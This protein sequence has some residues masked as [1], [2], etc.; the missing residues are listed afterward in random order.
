MRVAIVE[1]CG[2]LHDPPIIY[3]GKGSRKASDRMTENT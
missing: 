2:S 3:A 1:T